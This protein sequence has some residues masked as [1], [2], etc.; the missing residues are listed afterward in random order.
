[1]FPV[2]P[3]RG[4]DS[5]CKVTADTQFSL[6]SAKKYLGR[7]LLW[8]SH[9]R[10][11]HTQ[12]NPT[13]ELSCVY[14]H[15]SIVCFNARAPVAQLA[16][17][18]HLTDIQKTQVQILTESQGLFSPKCLMVSYGGSWCLIM[19]HDVSWWL[20]IS[21]NVSQ[22]LMYGGT[23]CLTMF[24]DVSLWLMMSHSVSWCHMVAHDVSWCLKWR[25]MSHGVSWCVTIWT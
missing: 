9:C 18:L 4:S 16:R 6:G 19:S 3:W 5:T 20:M 25:M 2:G 7:K 14:G 23:W 13:W 1:M 21:Q 10:V 11:K 8:H 12:R 22:C 15:L 24:R 17:L